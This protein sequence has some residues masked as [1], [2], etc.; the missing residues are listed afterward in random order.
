MTRN[1]RMAR[2]LRGM[3]GLTQGR[4]AKK[5]LLHPSMVTAIEAGEVEPTS[6]HLQRIAQGAG[7][8]AADADE[9]LRQAE[10]L[11]RYRERQHEGRDEAL[12]ALMD[13][14]KRQLGNVFTRLRALPDPGSAPRAE[15][16]RDMEGLMARLKVRSPEVRV[17]IVRTAEEFQSP[18][19]C[20]RVREEA[21]RAADAGEAAAW[22][23]L[24]EE[25][26]RQL[27]EPIESGG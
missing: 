26:A 20:E 22:A 23:Q 4:F 15:E 2:M 9:L 7:L 19:L 11:V 17:W 8:T 27:P 25:I 13:R 16:G 12:P 3:T 6:Q 24:A 18:A 10:A 1:Q 5:A 14:L 21:R